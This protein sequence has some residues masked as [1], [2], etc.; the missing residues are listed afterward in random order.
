MAWVSA[1]G[2]IP[3]FDGTYTEILAKDCGLKR[4]ELP[5]EA[6]N[7]VVDYIPGGDVVI[8]E[9]ISRV[10]FALMLIYFAWLI[11]RPVLFK[12]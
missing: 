8:L 9:G 1:R 10:G 5:C 6:G 2:V 4:R 3:Y 7:L 11:V 12:R